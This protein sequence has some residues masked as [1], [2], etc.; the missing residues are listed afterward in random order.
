MVTKEFILAGNA[1]FTV[2]I[3]AKFAAANDLPPH[4]TFKVRHKPAGGGY[5]ETWFVSLLTGPD[6][7]SD[8]SYLGMLYPETGFVRVTAKSAYRPE[9]WPVRVLSRI[10]AA[11]WENDLARVENHGWA[12]HH[13]GR[14]GRCGR[15][16]TVPESIRTGLGPECAGKTSNRVAVLG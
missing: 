9:S 7:T 2:E 3:E 1:I 14:C 6:N 10:L 16:L 11:V 12:I 8:Y 15:V 13:E 5:G 4:Y